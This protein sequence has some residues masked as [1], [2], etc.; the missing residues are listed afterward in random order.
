MREEEE[1]EEKQEEQKD[2]EEDVDLEGDNL[3][4]NEWRHGQPHKCQQT[5]PQSPWNS[6]KMQLRSS[7]IWP[8]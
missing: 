1:E 5:W 7:V 8:T 2:Q 4:P 6:K 3:P